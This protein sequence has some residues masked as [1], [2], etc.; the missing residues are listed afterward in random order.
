M[1]C[2][3]DKN[4]IHKYLDNTIDPLELIFLKEHIAVCKDCKD[5][6]ELMSKLDDSLYGYFDGILQDALPE[7]FSMSVLDKCFEEKK[8]TLKQRTELVVKINKDI[9]NNVTRFANYLPGSKTAAI[10]R[11]KVGLGLNRAV[12]SCFNYGVKKLISSAVK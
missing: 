12:K 9:I 7:N 10:L 1:I 11:K 5:E 3:F 4:I 6:I 2:K 8:L